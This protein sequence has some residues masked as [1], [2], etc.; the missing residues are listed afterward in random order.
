MTSPTIVEFQPK[1]VTSGVQRP[2]LTYILPN[3]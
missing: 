1:F 2:E 3:C